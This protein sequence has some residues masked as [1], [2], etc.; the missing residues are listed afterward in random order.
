M[1]AAN[2]RVRVAVTGIGVVSPLGIGR[3]EMWRSVEE[4]RSGAGLITLF[5]ASDLPV[6]MA[7]EAHGFEPTDFMDRRAARRMD[8]YAQFAVASAKLAV[9]D[10]GLPIDRDGEGIGAII[11]NGGSGAT[12]REEQHIA[13]LERGVDRVSPFAIPLSVAN[14]GAGQVSME[15]GLHG[16][17]TAVSTACAAGTDAIGTA[18]DILRRGDARAMLAGGADTLVTPYFV[19]GF[20]AMRVLSHRNDDPAGAAR[21][22]D[23]DRDGFLIGEAGAVLVLERLDDARARGAEVICELAGYGASAD[24]YHITDPDPTGEPQARAV[25]AALEDAGIAPAQVD[26]VNAHGGASKP[27]DPTELLALRLALGDEAAARVAVSATKSMHGHCMGATGALEAAITA[28]AVREGLVPPTINLT[29]LDPACGGVDHVANAARPADLR[30]AMSTSF[31]LGGHNAAL[32]VTRADD[33][34]R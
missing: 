31:G 4:G 34:D 13:L 12:S 9:A 32:I 24:A 21:P 27:G 1:S 10:A 30:V 19:A 5:D 6:R 2:G 23:R 8:R 11:A 33:G 16:P 25:T 14:M 15:L 7:C 26:H 20:D 22:F 3:E 17:V 28:L 18:L 29:E